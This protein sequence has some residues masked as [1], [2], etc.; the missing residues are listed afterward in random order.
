MD[1]EY[2]SLSVQVRRSLLVSPAAFLSVTVD[3]V[4]SA[5]RQK[6]TGAQHSSPARVREGSMRTLLSEKLLKYHF[7]PPIYL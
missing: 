5:G 4:M 2:G 1:S 3:S 7:S 6:S